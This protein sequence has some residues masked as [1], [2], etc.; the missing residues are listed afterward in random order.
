MTISNNT[1]RTLGKLYTAYLVRDIN[2]RRYLN[3]KIYTGRQPG[4]WGRIGEAQVF[5]TEAAAQSCASNINRRRPSRYSAYLAE[6][7]PIKLRG[8]G[9]RIDG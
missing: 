5:Y 4:I 9:R 6:V 8:R 7:V 2:A 3:R 1:N